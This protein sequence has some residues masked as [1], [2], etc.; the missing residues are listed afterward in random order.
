MTAQLPPGFLIR[1]PTQADAQAIVELLTTDAN[2]V[3]YL[4]YTV[5]DLL[6]HWQTPDFNPDTNAWVVLAPQEQII[7]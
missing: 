2:T 5:N 4:H 7:G 1:P 3:D 6:A